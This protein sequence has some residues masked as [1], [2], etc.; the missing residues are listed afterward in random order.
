MWTPPTHLK[1]QK[2]LVHLQPSTLPKTPQTSAGLLEDRVRVRVAEGD[3]SVHLLPR[4]R[5]QKSL[6]HT[7]NTPS[8]KQEQECRKVEYESWKVEYESR[9]V[10]YQS[11]K[12]EQL[13]ETRDNL[14]RS[15]RRS[16]AC[17]SRRRRSTASPAP[18]ARSTSACPCRPPPRGRSAW[19]ARRKGGPCGS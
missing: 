10:K 1:V 16:C 17:A 2:P 11:R 6:K 5:D 18:R 12:V 15:A 19:C 9:K 13:E 4:A 8:H 3:L 7:F 14:R